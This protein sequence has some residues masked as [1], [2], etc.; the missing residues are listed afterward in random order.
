[1]TLH[2]TKTYRPAMAS[3]AGRKI[4]DLL[5]NEL[6]GLSDREALAALARTIG[7]IIASIECPQCQ[8][9]TARDV[10]EELMP[11]VIAMSTKSKASA[12]H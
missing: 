1:M 3:A 5:N 12:L 11:R 7:V 2:V 10:M 4:L 6:E 9:L 8:D